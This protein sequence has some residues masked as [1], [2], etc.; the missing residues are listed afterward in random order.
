MKKKD[1]LIDLTP[2]LD[3]ILVLFFLLLIQNAE[4]ITAVRTQLEETEFQQGIIEQE[5]AQ[6]SDSLD[7]AN[8]RLEAFSD[9]DNE[10]NRLL[11]ELGVLDD[12]KIV[13]EQ[14]IHFICIDY[15]SDIEP[16]TFHVTSGGEKLRDISI[17][18]AD[19]RNV[20]Q[21]SD[22]IRNEVNTALQIISEARSEALPFLILIRYSDIRQQEYQL[23]RE[24]LEAFINTSELSI[25]TSYVQN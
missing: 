4:I 8:E 13:A 25:Y 23:I 1:I 11:N 17:I 10:R 21:N 7:D 24:I 16:R 18:W 5:L 20:I 12:W 22:V 19:D 6:A 9:W 15:K 3:V 14:A 2:L